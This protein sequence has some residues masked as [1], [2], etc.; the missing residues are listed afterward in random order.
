MSFRKNFAFMLTT[1]P[2]IAEEIIP[3]EFIYMLLVVGIIVLLKLNNGRIPKEIVRKQS[4]LVWLLILGI[5]IGMLNLVHL[6][7]L[8]FARDIFYFSFPIIILIYISLLSMIFGKNNELLKSIIFAAAVLSVIY[9]INLLLNKNSVMN[10]S[11]IWAYRKETGTGYFI[12]PV[13]LS[14]LL[15]SKQF[16]FFTINKWK[17]I[18][19]ICLLS[20]HVILSFSRTVMIIFIIFFFILFPKRNLKKT[21]L[22]FFT[23]LIILPFLYEGIKI[24]ST[25]GLLNE[26]INKIVTSFVEMSKDEDWSN[27]MNIVANWRGY[28]TF[29]ALNEFH[30]L[31]SLTKIIGNGFGAEIEV[32][33]FAE[34]VGGTGTTIP[35][36]HNGYLSLLIKVGI[37]GLLAYLFFLLSN[38]YYYVRLVVYQK[39]AYYKLIL[40]SFLAILVFTYFSTGIFQVQ[41]RLVF[42][43]LI[44]YYYK[45]KGEY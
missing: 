7:T 24:F 15:F 13:A 26:Y 19:L 10:Q 17:K 29:S 14:I 35:V 20:S 3:G 2:L 45:Y 31:N 4:F 22:F 41:P 6:N 5:C 40:S 43:F 30:R 9:L 34:L 1:I 12:V 25:N 8:S 16:S 18:C 42:L 23:I 21:L 32:G 36:L 33:Y 37:S 27:K 38:I 44:G 11:N 28:E 39:N